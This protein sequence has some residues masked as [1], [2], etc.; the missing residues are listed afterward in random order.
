[1]LDVVG[2]SRKIFASVD[3]LHFLFLEKKKGR[4]VGSR[5]VGRMAAT[6][7]SKL[8]YSLVINKNIERFFLVFVCKEINFVIILIVSLQL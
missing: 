6:M 4:I 5:L 1:M 2:I 7:A 3:I 8:L